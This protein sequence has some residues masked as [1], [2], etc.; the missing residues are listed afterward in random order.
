MLLTCGPRFEKPESKA[1][2]PLED[3]KF[4]SLTLSYWK[5]VL[6]L[7]FCWDYGISASINGAETC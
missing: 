6:N 1:Y 2:W 3:V 7:C 5:V 4:P